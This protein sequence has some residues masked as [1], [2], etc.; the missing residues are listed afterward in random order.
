MQSQRSFG[1][2]ALIYALLEPLIGF[3]ILR[4]SGPLDFPINMTVVRRGIIM[5]HTVTLRSDGPQR[6]IF[7]NMIRPF[8]Q[9]GHD[10]AF[11]S[12]R[13]LLIIR[14]IGKGEEQFQ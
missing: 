7:W 9:M 8:A 6:T 4:F 13:A 3:M 12:Y 5:M 14:K 11:Y 1:G 10:K 2:K